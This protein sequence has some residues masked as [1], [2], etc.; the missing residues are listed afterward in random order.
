MLN[1]KESA[2]QM[3]DYLFQVETYEGQATLSYSH[4]LTPISPLGFDVLCP[5]LYGKANKYLTMS[6]AQTVKPPYLRWHNN[7][8]PASKKGGGRIYVSLQTPLATGGFGA[9]VLAHRGCRV[10]A[11]KALVERKGRR[12]WFT[13]QT[14]E[15]RFTGAMCIGLANAWWSQVRDR[16]EEARS[17]VHSGPLPL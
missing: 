9:W 11:A 16:A 15:Q 6:E 10:K 3:L 14:C 4:G 7:H 5:N 17:R 8:A 1:L 13:C 12:W 2:L